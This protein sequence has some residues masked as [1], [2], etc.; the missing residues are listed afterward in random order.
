MRRN[1]VL[2]VV[3]VLFFTLPCFANKSIAFKGHWN[4]DIK[5]LNPQLPVQ[6]WVEDNN[7]DLLLEFSHNIG[8]ICVT[9][10]NSMGEKFYSQSVDTKSI[11]SV[12]ISVE[13]IRRGD[14][15]SI[16]GGN[17]VVYGYILNN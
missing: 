11:S 4:A 7:K 10:T 1:K 6:A 17:N 8:V 2:S 16:T 9:I 12:V 14:I 3:L 13:E 15:L 5:S